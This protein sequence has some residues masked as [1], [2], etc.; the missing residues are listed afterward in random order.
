V[1]QNNCASTLDILRFWSDSKVSS[2]CMYLDNDNLSKANLGYA[3]STY[4]T[5]RQLLLRGDTGKIRLR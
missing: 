2:F 4:G 1:A 5:V 3:I